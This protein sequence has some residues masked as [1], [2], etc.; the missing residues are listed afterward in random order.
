ML[1]ASSLVDVLTVQSVGNPVCHVIQLF[2]SSFPLYSYTRMLLHECK[3][4]MV[5]PHLFF[6]FLQ[7]IKMSFLYLP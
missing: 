1:L 7:Q 2:S 5:L 3:L 6:Y 4:C